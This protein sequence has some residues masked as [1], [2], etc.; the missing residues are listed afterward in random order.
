MTEDMDIAPE[1]PLAFD[2]AGEPVAVSHPVYETADDGD[3]DTIRADAQ[4]IIGEFL[5]MMTAGATAL[6]VGQRMIVLAYLAGR[7]E[8]NTQRELARALN[9]SPSRVTQ[10]MAEIPSELQ[11]L[12]RLKGRTAKPRAIGE[13]E[14]F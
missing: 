4:T 8:A 10:I 12:C 1:I 9:V 7:V 13:E 14:T 5:S 2:E 11:S 6:Q 3:L